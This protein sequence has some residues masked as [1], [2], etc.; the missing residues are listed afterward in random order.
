MPH[1]K[2]LPPGTGRALVLARNIASK[3]AYLDLDR[4]LIDAEIDAF[5]GGKTQRFKAGELIYPP[6]APRSPRLAQSPQ[7]TLVILQRGTVELRL[8]TLLG[9]TPVKRVAPKCIF[10]E[11]ESVGISMIGTQAWAL[12][13]AEIRTVRLAEVEEALIASPAMCLRWIQ[14]ISPRLLDCDR[15]R[16]LDALGG[17][18]SRLAFLLIQLAGDGAC[19]DGFTQ[20][21]IAD[22]L[23]VYPETIRSVLGKMRR[24]GLVLPGRRRIELL[25]R[26]A[27]ARLASFPVPP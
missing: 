13:R 12:G 8:S 24:E 9:G 22:R 10:G 16:V 6:P 11:A 3:V 23:G 2:E 4:L 20:E 25:N 26:A 15:Q 27:L 17:L 14:S 7:P 19:V 21:A 1:R 5:P 18:K